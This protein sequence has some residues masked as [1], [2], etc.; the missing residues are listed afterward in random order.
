MCILI[1]LNSKWA[2]KINPRHRANCSSKYQFKSLAIGIENG[3]ISS[4]LHTEDTSLR[5]LLFSL[6]AHV[7]FFTLLYYSSLLQPLLTKCSMI[8]GQAEKFK[9]FKL[10][11]AARGHSIHLASCV[12]LLFFRFFC[13]SIH[14]YKIY[15]SS[16]EHVDI[17]LRL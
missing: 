3:K 11:L 8:A 14:T 10:N 5:L 13:S 7:V 12:L 6:L 15:S 17:T 4:R 1:Q 2:L 9:N 16:S